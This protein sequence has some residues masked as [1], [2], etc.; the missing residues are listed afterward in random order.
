M[1]LQVVEKRKPNIH[2]TAVIDPQAE[3]HSNVVIGP[4][5]V[6]GPHTVIGEGTQIDAHA[7]IHPYTSIGKNCH[8][9]P[10]TSIGGEP[11]DLKYKGETSYVIIGDHT[12]IREFVTINRATGEGE[13]TRIGSHCLLQ[14]CTHVAHNCVVG[15]HIV[16][17]SFAGLA[18]HV[19]VEDRAVIGGM[20]GVH[21]FVKVGRNA[22]VGAMTKVVQDVPPFV[23]ADGNPARVVG[24]NNVGL[25][26]S[27]VS[28]DVKRDLKRA[29]RLLYR[30]NLTLTEAIA[31]MEHELHAYEEIEHLLRFLRNCERGIVRTR[32]D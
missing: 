15:N 17:S 4:Y 3:L 31:E 24:L 29:Y 23:I 14:A 7:V 12:E 6:I 20:A 8:I 18:G 21:Q 10:S 13:E 27:G 16:V 26:R 9:F 19:T 1:E 28:G 32:K 22:M 5:V 2:P 25:A 30:S 11:Q